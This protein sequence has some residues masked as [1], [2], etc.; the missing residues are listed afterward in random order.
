MNATPPAR[1]LGPGAEALL[2]LA[3]ISP[4]TQCICVTNAELLALAEVC[5]V[6][7]P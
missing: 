7:C 1:L 3:H 5:I 4:D 2:R 6:V